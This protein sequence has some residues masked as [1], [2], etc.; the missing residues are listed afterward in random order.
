M[1]DDN[2]WWI[3]SVLECTCELALGRHP[4]NLIIRGRK[5]MVTVRRNCHVFYNRY[6]CCVSRLTRWTIL[7]LIWIKVVHCWRKSVIKRL[8]LRAYWFIMLPPNHCST[9]EREQTPQLQIRRHAILLHCST[10]DDHHCQQSRH[11]H[12]PFQCIPRHRPRSI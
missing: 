5:T 3:S 4:L 8:R 2:T 1:Q 11:C 9:M 6:N 10:G 7:S 12:H